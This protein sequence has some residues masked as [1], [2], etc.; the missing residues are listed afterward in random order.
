MLSKYVSVLFVNVFVSLN[1]QV[2]FPEVLYIIN[3][4][5]CHNMFPLQDFIDIFS[6]SEYKCYTYTVKNKDYNY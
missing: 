6:Q 1:Y 2:Y 3:T 4:F 5:G